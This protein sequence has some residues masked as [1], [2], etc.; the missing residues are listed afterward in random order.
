MATGQNQKRMGG[1]FII[2]P[3]EVYDILQEINRSSS[4]LYY[5]ILR[6]QYIQ[7]DW[8]SDDTWVIGYVKVTKTELFTKAPISE[9]GF[10]DSAWPG[11]VE[12][13]L[14]DTTQDGR[15]V[16]PKLKKKADVGISPSDLAELRSRIEQLEDILKGSGN[17][18]ERSCQPETSESEGFPSNIE[19]FPSNIEG[20]RARESLLEDLDG[21]DLSL[22]RAISLFYN[23]IGQTKISK[24]KRERGK[25]IYEKLIEDGFTPEQ[26][27]FAVEWTLKNAKEDLYDFSILE[28]TIGQAMAGMER[29]QRKRAEREKRENE[30]AEM[31]KKETEEDAERKRILEHKA[32]LNSAARA[33]LRRE[34]EAEI[35]NSGQ[36][37]DDFIDDF[38]VE[39]KENQILRRRLN[40]EN[41]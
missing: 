11:L 40:N 12:A 3:F 27:Q 31:E 19:G 13:G 39:I 8:E 14:I 33:E 20:S 23:G 9:G 37:K 28:H 10:Y 17:G 25:K 2:I 15:I 36:F 30:A 16:L 26:I 4:S 7:E 18:P 1:R 22:S 32:S 6:F 5:S 21:I 29:E 35:K 24:G 38:L 41:S 34:A